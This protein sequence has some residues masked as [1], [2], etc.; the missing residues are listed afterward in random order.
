MTGFTD[1]ARGRLAAEYSRKIGET[2]AIKDDF[3]QAVE[4][5]NM[6][7]AGLSDALE[8]WRAHHL[9]MVSKMVSLHQERAVLERELVEAGLENLIIR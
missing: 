5:L 2:A 4:M 6:L 3:D 1:E 7:G 9:A 8:D